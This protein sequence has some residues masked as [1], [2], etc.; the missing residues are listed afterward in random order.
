MT[1][2][3][4]DRRTFAELKD[5]YEIERELS[6]RLRYASKEERRKLY[7]LVYDE[8]L[9]R[10]PLHPLLLQASSSENQTRAVTPQLRLLKHFL[11]PG[12]V[13]LEIG[14]GDCAL[15]MAMAKYVRQVVAVDVSSGLVQ[16]TPRP[17]NFELRMTDGISIPVSRNS[18]D[19]AYSND[20]MEHLHP[21][22][23]N[24]Q[25]RNIYHALSPGGEYICITPN[26]ISGPW[27]ISRH[28]DDVATG[29][30]LKEYSHTELAEALKHA[31]FSKVRI[32]MSY[33]GYIILPSLPVIFVSRIE[34]MIEKFPRTIRKNFA[35]FLSVFKVI[36]TK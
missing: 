14:P 21:E 8:R 27:D 26:R 5:H 15:A 33:A 3:H 35:Q 4:G 22:D 23:A 20:V 24:D 9:K 10:I 16:N 13:Y 6:D 29:L 36:A 1:T 19:L 25:L 18:I 30:H 32:L 17:D 11:K 31:G 28:F 12:M 2:N 7:H 34:W